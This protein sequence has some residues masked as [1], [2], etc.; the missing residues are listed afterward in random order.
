LV[1]AIG[2]LSTMTEVQP[3]FADYS[4]IAEDAQN[5]T[6]ASSYSDDPVIVAT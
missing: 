2:A 4:L 3:T 5:I 1:S 6:H